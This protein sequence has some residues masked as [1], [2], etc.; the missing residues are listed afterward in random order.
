MESSS[1]SGGVCSGDGQAL[2]QPISPHTPRHRYQRL[3]TDE[4]GRGSFGVVFPSWDCQEQRLV[5]VK[6]QPKTSDEG[7]REMHFGRYIRS[8]PNVVRLL[9]QYLDGDSLCLV[10][11]YFAGS[12]WDVW[13]RACGF[14]DWDLVQPY[15]EDIL[16]GLAFL[17]SQGVVHRD[18]TMP[19]I[20]YDTRANAVVISDLGMAVSAA[21]FIFDCHVTG[22]W[23]RAPEALVG[24][25]EMPCSQAALDLWSAGVVLA[26]LCCGSL[27]FRS[28]DW[29]GVFTEQVQLLGN[30]VKRWPDVV[31]LTRW[32]RVS[33]I[34][35][36]A[37]APTRTLA[38]SLC[39]P[40]MVPRTVGYPHML[41]TIAAVLEWNPSQRQDSLQCSQQW[42]HCQRRE[43]KGEII[44]KDS[45]GVDCAE[46]A[47][48]S[49]SVV[50]C[51]NV[52]QQGTN[53][54][55]GCSGSCGTLQCNRNKAFCYFHGKKKSGQSKKVTFC[56]RE[57]VAGMR[58]CLHCK[59][60]MIACPYSKL[61]GARWCRIHQEAVA[62]DF[63]QG[64]RRDLYSNQYGVHEHDPEWGWELRAVAEHGW[65]LQLM[66]PCDVDA[67]MKYADTTFST[68][69][70]VGYL[71][72]HALLRLWIAA[73]LKWPRAVEEW[74]RAM[75]AWQP[76]A[77]SYLDALMLVAGCIEDE[78][79]EWTHE[80]I[81][82]GNQNLWF[83]PQALL[84]RL[85]I[86]KDASS[87]VECGAAGVVASGPADASPHPPAEAGVGSETSAASD[88]QP[89]P[90]DILTEARLGRGG[91]FFLLSSTPPYLLQVLVEA[92]DRMPRCALPVDGDPDDCRR[93]IDAVGAF[94]CSFPTTFGMGTV[95][96]CGTATA[97]ANKNYVRKNIVR[98]IVLWG[99]SVRPSAAWDSLTVAD[100]AACLP[101][102]NGYL[103]CLRRTLTARQM[104]RVFGVDGFMVG[105]WACL[106]GGV[107]R[108]H[109]RLF[110]TYWH[111][112]RWSPNPPPIRFSL[113]ASCFKHQVELPPPHLCLAAKSSEP[114][115]KTVAGH[116]FRKQLC[117]H[118]NGFRS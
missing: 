114:V 95:E 116:I 40:S 82:G 83:G 56:F 45:S 23:Y 110:F 5:A 92:A 117:R 13:Q 74:G 49:A 72:G 12:L 18:L 3:G 85:G 50:A 62:S 54:V 28:K 75:A 67:F 24:I 2:L 66:S 108:R 32:A 78:P 90:A 118:G 77:K 53:S 111:R 15:G 30:P 89:P 97:Q 70:S 63:M 17:H 20:L 41:D 94:L 9:D 4:I 84:R 100:L 59:C 102:K 14:V 113:A 68:I 80:Q 38:D 96:K 99:K 44:G 34:A 106:A 65:F 35:D 101:D 19:N 79:M 109:R 29:L 36:K 61:Y 48:S 7:V 1:P 107:P 21:N 86:A 104:R 39:N 16:N 55:C 71:D 22:I 103:N 64:D 87:S 43:V 60:E 76:T 31:R 98:K 88:D 112:I 93:W 42:A 57:P 11:P 10:F 91:K 6:K 81:S 46:G 26:A 37:G 52:A 73:V 8:H 33:S 105:C 27:L 51:T 58:L 69:S 25:Q 47:C 115:P